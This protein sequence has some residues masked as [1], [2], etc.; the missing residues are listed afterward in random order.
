M[1]D[2]GPRLGSPAAHA[3][4]EASARQRLRDSIDGCP[5]RLTDPF[6]WALVQA[7]ALAES[8]GRSALGID[9]IGLREHLE[10]A[11][12]D[13]LSTART[14]LVLLMS[15]LATVARTQDPELIQGWRSRTADAHDVLLEIY[16]PSMSAWIPMASLWSRAVRHVS[17]RF[18][19]ARLKQPILPTDCPFG[20][21]EL[22]A[23]RPEF[24][25]LVDRLKASLEPS[26]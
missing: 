10:E 3:R 21:E 24:D 25:R 20:I 1:P 9:A 22:V 23:P 8:A 18:A 5:D 12:A 26:A 17:A 14:A 19:D 2:L 6:A 16:Q 11:A 13:F 15:Q 7:D 4:S